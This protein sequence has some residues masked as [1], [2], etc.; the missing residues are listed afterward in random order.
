MGAAE[1]Y[2]IDAVGGYD[3]DNPKANFL[4]MAIVQDLPL[5]HI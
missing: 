1:S 5:I 4:Y 3:D 2:I